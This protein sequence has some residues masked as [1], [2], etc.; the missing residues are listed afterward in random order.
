[1]AVR[2]KNAAH[3]IPVLH[4]VRNIGHDEIDAG[5]VLVVGEREPRV[6]D[7][8]VVAVFEGGHVLADFA[9]AAEK[10]NF[11]RLFPLYAPDAPLGVFSLVAC[12]R[13]SA[14]AGPAFVAIF[15]PRIRG[16]RNGPGGTFAFRPAH[17]H[18]P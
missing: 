8:D 7:D 11:Y 13:A 5:H 10:E 14:R 4:Q 18:C 6:D 17:A 9:H 1:M 16:G 15:P 3:L 2:Q 12:L